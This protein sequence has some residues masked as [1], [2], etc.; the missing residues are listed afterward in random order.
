MMAKERAS[1]LVVLYAS[2]TGNAEWMAKH[3]H[4]EALAKGF[5]SECFVLDDFSKVDLKKSSALVIV[6]S[7]TGDGDPPDNATK[8]WRWLRRAKKDEL[9]ALKGKQYALLGLGDTNYSNFC[10]TAKRLDRKFSDLGAVPFCPKGFA[11]DATGLEEVVD[12]WM[13]QLWEILPSVVVYDEEKYRAYSEKSD[14]NERKLK[15][16]K[17]GGEAKKEA[18]EKDGEKKD[19]EKPVAVEKGAETNGKAETVIGKRPLPVRKA[20]AGAV[21]KRPLPV[22]K[23]VDIPKPV[24]TK[25]SDEPIPS[26]NVDPGKAPTHAEDHSS[27]TDGLVSHRPVSPGR[28][29]DAPLPVVID[30]TLLAA[31][32]QLTGVAKLPTEFLTI[33]PLDDRRTVEESRSGLFHLLKKGPSGAPFDHTVSAPFQA[34][35]TGVRCL[36]GPRAL[37]RVIEITADIGGLGWEYV[38]G[39]AFG[40]LCPNTDGLVLPLLKRLG[41]E[42]EHVFKMEATESAGSSGLPFQLEKPCTYYE[43]FRHFLDLHSLPRK[44]FLR[45]LAEYTTDEEEKKTLYF[46]SSTQGT[47]A[48]R[49]LRPQQPTLLD[50]LHTFPS[51]NPPFARL[52]ET[53]PR[54]QPRYYSVASS[55]LTQPTSV[56]FAFNIVDYL[57]E[58]PYNKP[59]RGLCS[60]W[61]DELTG[62]VSEPGKL[63]DLSSQ[64]LHIPIFPKPPVDFRLPSS[65]SVPIIMI[66]AGTGLTPFMGF[67]RHRGA[68]STEQKPGDAWLFHGRRFA[69]EDG[70]A[71]Y[72]SELKGLVEKGALTHLHEC[73]SR[74]NT[75]AVRFKYVQD[76]VK[77][78]GAELWKAVK[79]GGA[80]IYVC[81]SVNMAKEVNQ[82]FVDIAQQHGGMGSPVEGQVFLTKLGK[83]K[84]YLRDLWN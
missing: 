37:K 68:A 16:K 72:L 38:P 32:K 73:L 44:S 13:A 36:T 75:E 15:F 2:Q 81:G 58:A 74:E 59:M 60:T 28:N 77:A 63:V 25:W 4:E 34:H 31:A 35:I 42:P 22:R 43:A 24:E 26:T 11:D 18:G 79:E 45:M 56:S 1:Q 19:A 21:E 6:A 7:T 64:N 62:S 65:P 69:G 57:T 50:L 27:V 23:A 71:L 53:I 82:A 47:G 80:A 5:S 30:K 46:L 39:D 40:V 54:L 78:H 70:D 49:T 10:N 29:Y 83:E 20:A 61:L 3:V 14:G 12:P 17:E 52:L 76:A 67:L 8:F 51:C 48:Y 9:E 66:A 33:T 84:R 55:P 41:L